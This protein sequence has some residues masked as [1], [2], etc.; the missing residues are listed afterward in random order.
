MSITKV[1]KIAGV[2]SSTVS[3]VIN[4]HPR[5]APATVDAVRRAMEKLSYVPSDRRPG[6]KPFR[7]A[8]TKRANIRFLALG[9]VRGTA[10]PGFSEL[11]SGISHAAAHHGLRLTFS[12]VPE[13]GDLTRQL[14]QDEADGLLLHGQLPTAA[15]RSQLSRFPTVWLMGNRTRPNWG[16]QVMPDA[17][18][19]GEL[20]AGHLVE[21][22]HRH[23]AFLNLEA[24]FWPYRVREHAFV[25]TARSLGATVTALSYERPAVSSYWEPHG[26][27]AVEQLV[28]QLLEID[29]RPTGLFVADDMQISQIQPALQR[30]GVEVG[31]GKTALIG[32]NNELPYLAGLF[33]RP[34]SIDIRLSAIGRHAVNQL[35]WRLEHRE[36][37]DR[38][39]ISIAPR[40]AEAEA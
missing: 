34:A 18:A 4:D 7:R 31:P 37:A 21:A 1:A 20:A 23:L 32:C 13:P 9:S 10:T 24:C 22:G 30:R 38:I 39:S 33:P 17:Y 12:H 16:D 19:I 11:L 27:E 6:P 5:V 14:R 35:L 26:P 2:S 25:A 36:V 3:R 29:P 15:I 8:A 40:I 28:D